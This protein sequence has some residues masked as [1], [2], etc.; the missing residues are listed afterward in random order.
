MGH[1][2]RACPG[3]DRVQARRPVAHQPEAGYLEG[4]RGGRVA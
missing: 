4:R 3:D 2:A 1:R